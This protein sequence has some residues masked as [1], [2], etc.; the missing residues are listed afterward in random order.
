MR[1]I[2]LLV[3]HCSAT[4]NGKSL[5]GGNAGSTGVIDSWHS[6]RGFRRAPAAMKLFNP[7]LKAIGY[8]YVIN[9]DGSVLTGRSPAE[10]GAHAVNA[11][12]NSLGI[13]LVGTD[14]FTTRQWEEL[15]KLV[16]FLCDKHRIPFAPARR[17]KD[18]LSDGICGHRTTSP[19]KNGNG[20]VE[21][22]E[23]L[24]TCPGFDV[25][26]WLKARAPAANNVIA[27]PE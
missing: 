3:I 6:T 27:V 4:A 12:A 24:K 9:P 1:S 16:T 23:W 5:A 13:C 26:L 8:H 25:D 18:A 20:K 14:K 10:V 19:D 7:S 11:N 22:F 2:N 21:P 17:A 15:L